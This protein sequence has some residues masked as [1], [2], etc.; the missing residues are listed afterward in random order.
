LPLVF[1]QWLLAEWVGP[2][3]TAGNLARLRI[4][5]CGRAFEAGW[6]VADLVEAG[7][8][9]RALADVLQTAEPDGL[10]R[11]RLLWSLR[12]S[13]PWARWGDALT[14]FELAEDSEAGRAWLRK[15]PDLLLLDEGSP[16]VIVSGQGVVFQ[17]TLF[18]EAPRTIELKS[19]R[20]FDGIEYELLIGAYRFRLVN[21]PAA[22]VGRLD[23]WFRFLFGEFFPQVA[24]VHAWQAPQGSK[25]SQFHEV[26]ACPECRRSLLPRAG[27]VGKLLDRNE[28]T[29]S[30][31]TLRPA[32][33]GS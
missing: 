30:L 11:L 1:A 2:W 25:S 21:D 26:V 27:D 20:D 33:P 31:P 13:R 18:T 16:A 32:P 3:W 9:A 17:E 15:Y 8:I 24:A 7:L 22:L 28:T 29:A 23:R 19:R 12:P 14:V 4:L 10:A 6:E 5:L